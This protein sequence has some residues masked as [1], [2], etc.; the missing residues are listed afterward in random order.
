MAIDVNNVLRFYFGHVFSCFNVFFVSK[1]FLFKKRWQSSETFTY[2]LCLTHFVTALRAISWALGV[3]LNK[4]F[5][6]NLSRFLRF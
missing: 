6:L 5:F 2:L 4:R 3:E 1:R